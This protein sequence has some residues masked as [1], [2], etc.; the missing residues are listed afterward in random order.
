[1]SVCGVGSCKIAVVEDQIVETSTGA[2]VHNAKKVLTGALLGGVGNAD[3]ILTGALPGRV[4]NADD[5][6]AG[7]GPEG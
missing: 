7:W 2:W 1:M 4:K 5:I 3:E 6:A